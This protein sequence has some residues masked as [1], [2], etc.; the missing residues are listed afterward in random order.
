MGRRDDGFALALDAKGEPLWQRRIGGE[1]VDEASFAAAAR[2]PNAA[3]GDLLWAGFTDSYGNGGR[4]AF[5]GRISA[6]SEGGCK[7][8]D[9][10][11]PPWKRYSATPIAADA[12]PTATP[13]AKLRTVT[14]TAASV[15]SAANVGPT[16]MCPAM[17]CP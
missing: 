16:S 11:Q 4:E 3:P 17:T 14:A 15:S 10:E 8:R 2:G 6:A 9:P 7:V 1:K 12:L 5:A 13:G